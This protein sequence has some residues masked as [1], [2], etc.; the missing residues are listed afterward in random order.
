M[1]DWVVTYTFIGGASAAVDSDEFAVIAERLEAFEGSVSTDGQG[2][3]FATVHMSAPS[4]AAAQ[5][6]AQ[7][8]LIASGV[9]PADAI[10]IE[11]TTFDE[12]ERLA[13]A[14]T[15]PVLLGAAEVGDLL[16]VSRQRVHQLTQHSEFPA[17][18]VRV[19]MG[20]LWDEQAIKKFDREWVRKPGRPK[21]AFLTFH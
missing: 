9:S 7:E 4:A 20:P 11:S 13:N 12:Y 21:G 16:G 3:W 6:S 10:A 19:R 15:L 17:P 2:R 18:L 5:L 8:R 1:T 14:P